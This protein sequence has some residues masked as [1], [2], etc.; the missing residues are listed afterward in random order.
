MSSYSLWILSAVTIPH[1]FFCWIWQ[2]QRINNS[3]MRYVMRLTPERWQ[4]IYIPKLLTSHVNGLLVLYPSSQSLPCV[5]S[6][7]LQGRRGWT[8]WILA[9][10]HIFNFRMVIVYHSLQFKLTSLNLLSISSPQ[11]YFFKQFARSSILISLFHHDAG[12]LACPD[13]TLTYSKSFWVLESP[14]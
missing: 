5:V 13:D 7:F 11:L 6:Y 3:K 2:I 8:L 9:I 1:L 14:L 12:L 4:N 10:T